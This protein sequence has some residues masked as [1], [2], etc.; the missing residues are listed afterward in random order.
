MKY[1]EFDKIIPDLKM[2]ICRKAYLENKD[3]IR[4]KKE[5]LV[6]INLGKIFDA[7]LEIGILKGFQAM[8]MRDLSRVSG[9]SMGGLY[10]YFSSKEQILTVYLGQGRKIIKEV[11]ERFIMEKTLPIERLRTAVQ[12]HLFLTEKMHE[13]FFFSYMEAKN[14]S[15][16]ER[17]RSIQG[18]LGT[19]KMFE[20]ILLDG[21]KQGVFKEVNH[22]LS[23]SVIKAMLQ[24]WYLKRWKYAKR[25]VHVD[26]YADFIMA[27]IAP[28][29]IEGVPA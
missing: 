23:A 27:F 21:Q 3:K 17:E 1:S 29:C 6:V 22:T 14:L 19:E 10:S 16:E 13:F 8:T 18:E 11:L 9:L 26:Q 25:N 28:F 20:E 7:T 5:K 15:L 24:D 12:I 2:D 4:I